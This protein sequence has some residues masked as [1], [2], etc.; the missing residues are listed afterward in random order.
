[1]SP[2]KERFM[3]KV[4]PEPNTG[5]WLWAAVTSRGYGQICGE[6]GKM[7]AAHRTSYEMFVGPISPGLQIDHL[8]KVTCCVNP[9]HLEA[10]TPLVNTLRSN[11]LAAVHARK[12]KCPQGH[13]YSGYDNR[14]SRVCRVCQ[15]QAEKRSRIRKIEHG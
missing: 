2:L 11:G 15:R 14:G 12:T 13:P 5:C 1:M 3:E 10:V 7:K 9:E 4:S 6:D 8:C